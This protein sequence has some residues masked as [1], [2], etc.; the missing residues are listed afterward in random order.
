MQSNTHSRWSFL[1][2]LNRAMINDSEMQRKPDE[3]FVAA[4]LEKKQNEKPSTLASREET[5]REE[6]IAH[7]IS[8][9]CPTDGLSLRLRGLLQGLD[10]QLDAIEPRS[11]TSEVDQAAVSRHPVV[12]HDFAIDE[13]H[14]GIS[15]GFPK[16]DV[17]PEAN[18]I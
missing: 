5:T 3:A 14:F 16:P 2:A 18:S 15:T 11:G 7:R 10:L 6:T 4:V 12:D 17:R 8:H 1:R 13:R 9:V